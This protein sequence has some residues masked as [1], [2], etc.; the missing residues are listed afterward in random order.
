MKKYSESEI[1]KLFNI[2]TCLFDNSK[3]DANHRAYEPTPYSV[4]DLI[5]D[6]DFLHGGDNVVDMGSGK[7][8]VGFYLSNKIG[9]HV[10][11]IEY[12][13][14]IYR[15]ALENL[16]KVNEDVNV[17][18]VNVSAEKYIIKNTD[19]AFFFFNPFSDKILSKVLAN[20]KESFYEAPR[21]IKLIFYY[22]TLEY[23]GKLISDD[24]LEF[25]DEI[26]CSHLFFDSKGR[27]CV[28]IFKVGQD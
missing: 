8:R 11:G 14:D 23:V 24:L 27:E 13:E 26:D 1:D 19:N 15:L 6:G 2:E 17:S 25:V 21:E 18:F 16:S 10:T 4:L 28:M 7:G 22:P 9:C 20:I 12:N 3:E 5:V